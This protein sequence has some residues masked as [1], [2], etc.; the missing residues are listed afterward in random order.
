M[1]RTALKHLRRVL[2][3]VE[4]EKRNFDINTF[5]KLNDNNEQEV[6]VCN[7]T[8]CAFGWCAFDPW[9]NRA[10]LK[11]VRPNAYVP[12]LGLTW[13]EER[14]LPEPEIMAEL[15]GLPSK[16]IDNIFYPEDYVDEGIVDRMDQ[17]TPRH[18][19]DKVEALLWPQGMPL[20]ARLTGGRIG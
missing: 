14:N 20:I 2:L 12:I 15:F 19:L 10:G 11:I 18:V 5:G 6:K 8:A 13:K 3:T 17:V 7:T 16:V 1:N 4:K 9:F